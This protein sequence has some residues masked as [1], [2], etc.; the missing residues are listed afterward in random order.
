MASVPQNP[1]MQP[2][3]ANRSHFNVVDD[4]LLYDDRLVILQQLQLKMLDAIHQGHLG[5]TKCRARAR[6]AIWWQVLSLRIEEMVSKKIP[7][8]GI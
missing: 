6:E 1:I 3:F 7:K 5:I 8:N 4:L 2:Y